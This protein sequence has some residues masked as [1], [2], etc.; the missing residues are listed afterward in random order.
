MSDLLKGV[1]WMGGALLSFTGMIIAVREL[2]GQ[3]GT[4]QI[5]VFR[6]ATALIIL[7]PVIWHAGVRALW[8]RRLGTHLGRNTIHFGGQWAW[9]FAVHYLTMAEVISIEF[10]MPMWAAVLAAVF[11][12]EKLSSNRLVAIGIGFAGVLIILQP[13][14]AVIQPAALIMLSGAFCFAASLVITKALTRSDTALA[15]IFWMNLMQLPMGLVLAVPAWTPLDWADLHW[16]F[17]TGGFGLAAHYSMAR[18]LKLADAGVVLPIDF[19]R[20]PVTALFGYLLYREVPSPWV[21]VGAAMI[22]GGNYYSVWV[23]SRRRN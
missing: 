17:L 15:I 1:C 14:I 21:F 2:T 13:G 4:S 20:L 16:M 18:A 22:F 10:T 3:Y 9:V 11:L 5:V 7:A 8:T 12:G 6:S 23:E 19:M